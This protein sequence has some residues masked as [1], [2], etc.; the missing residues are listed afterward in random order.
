MV[1]EILN[2][3]KYTVSVSFYETTTS[4]CLHRNLVEPRPVDGRGCILCSM[5]TLRTYVIFDFSRTE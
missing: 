1:I 4:R 2:A 5:Q 3:F